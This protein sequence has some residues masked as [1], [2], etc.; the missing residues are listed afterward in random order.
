MFPGWSQPDRT[1]RNRKGATDGEDFGLLLVGWAPLG[2]GVGNSGHG[3][4]DSPLP[5]GSAPFWV[6]IGAGVR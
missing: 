5:R 4:Q 1:D 2:P 6:G 3:G